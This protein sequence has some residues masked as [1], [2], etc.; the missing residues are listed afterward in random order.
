MVFDIYSLRRRREEWLRILALS[1]YF[2]L[3]LKVVYKGG[4]V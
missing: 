1:L 2:E 3:T 4:A